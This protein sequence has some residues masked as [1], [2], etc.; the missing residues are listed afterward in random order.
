M[1]RRKLLAAL[2]TAVGGSTVL[3]TG[4]FTSVSADRSVSVEVADDSNAFLGLVPGDTG[5]VTEDG[6]TLRINLDGTGTGASGVNFDAVTQ[7][8]SH[9][10]PAESHAF[11]IINQGTQSLMLKMNYYFTNTDWLNSGEGQSFIKFTIHDTGDGPTGSS[12]QKFPIQNGY[13]RDY[14][15]AQPTGSG[16]GSNT[17]DY[18]FNVGEEYYMVITVDTTGP[19][20]SPDDDLSGI[21]EVVAKPETNGYGYSRTDPPI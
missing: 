11:K 1:N 3:G 15:L 8:G 2:G 4:A 19:N 10:N 9:E 6:G 13:N 20:A 21:A 17:S 18:R 7:I 16:F 12:S 14:P 5:L